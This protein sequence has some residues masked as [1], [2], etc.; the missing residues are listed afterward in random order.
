M[1]SQ[2]VVRVAPQRNGQQAANAWRIWTQGDEFYAAPRNTI[3]LGKVSFHRGLNWQYRVGSSTIRLARPL[4]LSGAWLHILEI[5][6]LLDQNI[7]MPLDQ[8]EDSVTLIETPSDYK[9]LV[10]LMLFSNVKLP[11]LR[12]PPEIGGHLLGF[13]RLRSGATLIATYR[14]MQISDPDRALIAD[15][16]SK[17]RVHVDKQPT[18]KFYIEAN[19]N[20]FSPQTGNVIA[21]TSTGNEAIAAEPGSSSSEVSERRTLTRGFINLRTS[22]THRS[23]RR[24][25]L[26]YHDAINAD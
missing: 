26:C 5:S 17:L 4:E 10:N 6:F 13:Q 14:I 11:N 3:Q 20:E 19:W 7:L 18:G 24:Y 1:A 21:I 22:K 12:P 16:R 9:L 25:K 15:V 2:L 23:T 8:R